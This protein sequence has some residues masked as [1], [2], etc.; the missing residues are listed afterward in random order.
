MT[1]LFLDT[2]VLVYANG[3]EHAL[4]SPCEEVLDA[5]SVGSLQATT[6]PETIQEFAHAFA[7]RRGRTVSAEIATRYAI[8]LAP[9]RVTGAEHLQAGL[10]L[11]QVTAQLGAFDAV[12]AA[13]ALD[14]EDATVVSADR[15]FADVPGLRHV[16]PDDAGV[17]ELI[18]TS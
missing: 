17:A 12:L 8:L 4:K 18:D 5:I 7:R 13:V 1:V 15:A 6:T 11:W 9:L 10:A 3:G 16:F 2:N 14:S